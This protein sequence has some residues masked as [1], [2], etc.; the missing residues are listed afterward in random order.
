MA[1]VN[2]KYETQ[3]VLDQM[4]KR[5][6]YDPETGVLRWLSKPYQGREIGYNCSGYK[7]FE[8]NGRRYFLHRVVWAL[9]YGYWPINTIDHVDRDS[10]NNKIENLRDVTQKENNWNKGRYRATVG[11][12]KGVY[13]KEGYWVVTH[14]ETHKYYSNNICLGR[15]IKDRGRLENKGK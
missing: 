4:S 9:Y 14:P 8:F 5:L 13:C 15:A 3:E 10:T 1:K 6:N 2:S 7:R 11:K 12:P